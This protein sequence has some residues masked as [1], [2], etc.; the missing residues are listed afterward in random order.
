MKDY[1][2]LEELL[3]AVNSI[4]DSIEAVRNIADSIE[5][6][7][8]LKSETSQ[9]NNISVMITEDLGNIKVKAAGL[10]MEVEVVRLEGGKAIAEAL[11]AGAGK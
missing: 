8:S 11:L 2:N 10:A 4:G 9:L 3:Q 7:P 6:F 5:Q 1:D